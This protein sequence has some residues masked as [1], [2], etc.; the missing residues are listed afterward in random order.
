VTELDDRS[1]VDA[2][3][4]RRD[5]R[6]FGLLYDRHTPAMYGL[7]LR[8]AAG[9][10]SDAEDVVHDAWIKA[11]ERLDAFEWRSALRSWLCGFVV[12]RCREIRRERHREAGGGPVD[13]LVGAGAAGIDD[14]APT[15]STTDRRLDA[16]ADRVDLERA[17]RLLADGY[18]EVLV[19]HD[20]HGFT[21][22]EIGALLGIEAG[23]S[24]SQL[25]R[26]RRVLRQSLNEAGGTP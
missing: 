15:L 19:L 9:A 24:K 4:R 16:T 21:H 3:A 10:E 26:A 2:V 5:S 23:T 18:R 20:I 13:R 7:A 12:Y 6:A 17:V 14:E 25:S 8:L 11:V 22:E 1:L